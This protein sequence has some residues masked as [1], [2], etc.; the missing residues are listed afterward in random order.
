MIYGEVIGSLWAAIQEKDF[1]GKKLLIVESIDLTTRKK[2]G[3]TVLAIDLVGAGM[4]DKVLVIYEGGSARI[5]LKD[6]KTCA[7]AIVAGIVDQVDMIQG[8]KK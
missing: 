1:Q 5:A 4:G 3:E 7:E 8:Y 2:T 6:E